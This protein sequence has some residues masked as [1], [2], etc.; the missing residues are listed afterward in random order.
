MLPNTENTGWGGN[1]RVLSCRFQ[2]STSGQQWIK[3]YTVELK[4][5]MAAKQEATDS[6]SWSNYTDF[7][8]LGINKLQ[9]YLQRRGISC[10]DLQ[11]SALLNYVKKKVRK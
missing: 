8:H 11:K 5:N 2:T 3:V 10:A 6:V 4:S 9:F 1:R 7:N